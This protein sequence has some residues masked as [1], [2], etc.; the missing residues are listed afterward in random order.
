MEKGERS[1]TRHANG[2]M[3]IE[4]GTRH[5]STTFPT[6]ANAL[7]QREAQLLGKLSQTSRVTKNKRQRGVAARKE[8]TRVTE[9]TLAQTSRRKLIAR[10]CSFQRAPGMFA[11]NVPIWLIAWKTDRSKRRVRSASDGS[12]EAAATSALEV[13]ITV[14]GEQRQMPP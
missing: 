1:Q 6:Q 7:Q 5:R 9:A 4:K 14:W 12:A 3:L 2:V 13:R 8:R 11:M 10:T